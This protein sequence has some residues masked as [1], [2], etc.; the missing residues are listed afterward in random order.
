[1]PHRS[2][3]TRDQRLEVHTLHDVG[4]G[5]AKIAFQLSIT[6]GQVEYASQLRL[7]PHFKFRGVKGF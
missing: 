4:L 7:T 2:A 3:L 5:Y 1:M 6:Q